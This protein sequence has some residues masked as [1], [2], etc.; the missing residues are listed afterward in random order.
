[1]PQFDL[2]RVM[3]GPQNDAQRQ[4]IQTAKSI[5]NPSAMGVFEPNGL[6]ARMAR[7]DNVYLGGLPN[8]P[9]AGR[10]RNPT[11]NFGD[12]SS[13]QMQAALQRRISAYG[14]ETDARQARMARTGR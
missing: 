13:P 12:I 9:G 11:P 10:P 1:M 2:A 5:Q 8:A 3:V 7:G 6:Q 4:A 14:Q